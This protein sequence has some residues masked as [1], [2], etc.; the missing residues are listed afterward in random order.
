MILL[1]ESAPSEEIIHRVRVD[2]CAC[3]SHDSPVLFDPIFTPIF[4]AP[5][6]PIFGAGTALTTFAV[7]AATAAA[8]TALTVGLQ[9]LLAPSVRTPKSEDGKVPKMQAIPYRWWGVGRTGVAGAYSGKQ[10]GS[11]CSRFKPSSGTGSKPSTDT[12]CT[13]T[14][15]RSEAET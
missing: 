5:F 3:S 14:K 6:T 1:Y 7:G 8:I 10:R 2:L 11:A 13:M 15:P 12:F 9:L 4:T